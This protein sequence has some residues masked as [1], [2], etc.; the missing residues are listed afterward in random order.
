MHD[1]L[2]KELGDPAA[3]RRWAEYLGVLRA[4][5]LRVSDSDWEAFENDIAEHA[6][7]AFS[8]AEGTE[9]DRLDLALA[10]I[11]AADAVAA[12]FIAEST[13]RSP[14][15]L[16]RLITNVFSIAGFVLRSVAGVVILIAVSMAAVSLINPDTGLWLH[17]DGSWSISFESHEGGQQ[18]AR[19][20]FFIW[21]FAIAT[22]LGSGLYFIRR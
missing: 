8:D 18:V 14:T 19:E 9:S 1:P 20:T 12:A 6:A 15:T 5:K 3:R 2:A 7:A 10:Q 22:V 21:A 17:D 11:G 16:S 4:P 13:P